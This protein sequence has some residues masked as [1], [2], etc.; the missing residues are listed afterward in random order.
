[1][2]PVA[3]A[4]DLVELDA[5][6]IVSRATGKWRSPASSPVHYRAM[7]PGDPA[8]KLW[9]QLLRQGIAPQVIDAMRTV[10][11]PLFLP[12]S[13]RPSAW[14]NRALPIGH[15]QTISQP[16]IV[17]LMTQSLELRPTDRVLEI[18]TGSG[19]QA[20]ILSRLAAHLYTIERIAELQEAAR[21]RIE[22]LGI[23]NVS[24]R[25]GDGGAGWPEEAP[26]DAVIV[27]AAVPAIPAPLWTQLAEGGRM[28]L[29][30]AG[31]GDQ[32]LVLAR[33]VRGESCE[34]ILC[35]CA[36]VPLVGEFG[37]QKENRA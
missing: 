20:A 30:I 37:L 19:Y 11:R 3:T 25:V 28:V 34:R 36:F 8:E 23:R 35:P 5:L 12:E 7:E 26:F 22:S 16:Y 31:G 4:C 14:D 17:G 29:P 33:K 32:D 27:T 9:D 13:L 15:G 21:Q 2:R 6:F 1:M 10:P 24:F 18:G